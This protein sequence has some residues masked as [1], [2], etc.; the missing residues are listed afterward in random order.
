MGHAKQFVIRK[1]W[2]QHLD[3]SS[4]HLERAGFGRVYQMRL[5]GSTELAQSFED[6]ELRVLWHT[7]TFPESVQCCFNSL[8]KA[9]ACLHLQFRDAADVLHDVGT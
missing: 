9:L 4:P 3:R 7:R 2:Q 5:D 1:V 8:R 6:F